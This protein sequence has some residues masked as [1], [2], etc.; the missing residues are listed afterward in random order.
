[1]AVDQVS[2]RSVQALNAAGTQEAAGLREGTQLEGRVLAVNADDSLRLAT[3]YGLIDVDQ[4][5]ISLVGGRGKLPPPSELIGTTVKIEITGQSATSGRYTV[6]PVSSGDTPSISATEQGVQTPEADIA[7]QVAA[8]VSRAAARQDG[9]APVFAGARQLLAFPE[10]LPDDVSLALETLTSFSLD[11]AVTI[12]ADDLRNAVSASGLFLEAK[13]A[14]LASGVGDGGT[15]SQLNPDAPL[16]GQDLKAALFGLKSVLEDWIASA[17]AAVPDEA[18]TTAADGPEQPAN[19]A[20]LTSPLASGTSAGSAETAS[21]FDA[22]ALFAV[23]RP[24][25]VVAN[26][27]LQTALPDGVGSGAMTG[28]GAPAGSAGRPDL[29]TMAALGEWFRAAGQTSLGGAGRRT[30]YGGKPMMSDGQARAARTADTVANA[31]P[32]PP[33]RGSLPQGQAAIQAADLKSRSPIDAAREL[34]AKTGNALARVSL[35]QYASLQDRLTAG[36]GA[37]SLATGQ[38]A[39]Q[40]KVPTSWLFEIPLTINNGTSIAQFEIDQVFDGGSGIAEDSRAWRVQFSLDIA[41]I[42][43]IHARLVLADRR[44]SVGLWAEDRIGAVALQRGLLSLRQSLEAA[45][46]VIDDVHFTAGRPPSGPPVR[47]G[48]F[49]DRNA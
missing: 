28:Q 15:V 26:A 31:R 43:P 12:S 46:F 4:S 24:P 1:M 39:A 11:G 21:S 19:P 40:Q 48:G 8:E 25:P 13:L 20:G 36:S 45:N 34:A 33:R 49:F 35:G 32:P 44:L 6:K 29:V 5:Q 10:A 27:A 16:A 3:R 14:R 9:L 18:A 37:S 23:L 47:A 42:G 22:E 2:A 38:S 7:V 41:P 30:A 17:T